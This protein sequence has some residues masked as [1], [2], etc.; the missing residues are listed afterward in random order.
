MVLRKSGI[1]YNPVVSFDPRKVQNAFA[2]TARNILGQ[3]T[4]AQT[5][6]TR[7]NERSLEYVRKTAVK[8]LDKAIEQHGRPQTFNSGRLRRAIEDPAN[9]SFNVDGFK[10]LIDE[11]IEP[12]VPYYRAIEGG[13]HYWVGKRIVL[14]FL[15]PTGEAHPRS[16]SRSVDPVLGVAHPRLH[17]AIIGPRQRLAMGDQALNDSAVG[18]VIRNPVPA[19]HYGQ[20]AERLFYKNGI[21]KR[22][23]TQELKK[24][25]IAVK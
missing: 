1:E 8:E 10:F 18:V 19:Y 17:D 4:N 23:V 13:S 7:A 9:S 15:D 3:F 12:K 25:G 16:T 21:Y 5:A 2:I 24:V 14:N 20:S 6:V 22:Y 11:K